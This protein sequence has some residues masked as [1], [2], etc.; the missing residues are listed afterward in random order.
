MSE[1]MPDEVQLKFCDIR[2]TVYTVYNDGTQ[3]T[4]TDI[5]AEVVAERDALKEENASIKEQLSALEDVGLVLAHQKGAE[6][7]RPEMKKL[8]AENERLR[9]GLSCAKGYMLNA[10]FDL[11][12]GVKKADAV[13][14][15]DGGIR[16][17]EKA[18]QGGE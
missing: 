12:T 2:D 3:Y 1:K 13:C 7:M 5:H 8:K 18:L 10:K 4:R 15:L 6:M 17:I 11:E 16:K 14:T 9:E